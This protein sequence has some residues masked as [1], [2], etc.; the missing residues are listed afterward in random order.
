MDLEGTPFLEPTAS[1]LR[2]KKQEDDEDDIKSPRAQYFTKWNRR[3]FLVW[4]FLLLVGLLVLGTVFSAGLVL[5]RFTATQDCNQETSATP[6][7]SLQEEI[8]EDPPVLLISL[9]G[10]LEWLLQEKCN[11]C[12]IIIR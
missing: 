2:Y 4:G 12:S 10:F 6:A 9:D 11:S 8:C 3:C 7:P 1:S 5:G